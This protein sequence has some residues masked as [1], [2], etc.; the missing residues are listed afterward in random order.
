MKKETTMFCIQH[1]LMKISTEWA[2]SNTDRLGAYG[3]E[4]NFDFNY[5]GFYDEIDAF[6]ALIQIS[7]DY[8]EYLFRIVEIHMVREILRTIEIQ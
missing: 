4:R 5:T 6:K 2:F 7:K 1:K 3:G 8:P